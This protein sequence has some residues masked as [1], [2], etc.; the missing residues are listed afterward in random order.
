MAKQ[1]YGLS[2][3]TYTYNDQALAAGLLDSMAGWDCLPR[4]VLVVDDGSTV[5]FAA[6][7]AGTGVQVVRLDP[8]RGPA[9]AKIAGLSAAGSRFLL[10]LDADIRLD[11]DWVTRLLPVAARPEVGLV[12]TPIRTEA[13]SGLLADYQR[14]L[15]SHHLGRSGPVDVLPAGVW[16][17]RREVWAR[18]G[19]GEYRER[20]HEDVY[21]SEKLRRL[22][23][24]LW[25]ESGPEA[26]QIRR[27]GRR[28]MVRRGWTWQGREFAAVARAGDG[29]AVN[30]LLMAVRRRLEAHGA[31]DVRF[32]YYDYLYA[33]FALTDLLRE[34]GRP[35]EELAALTGLLVLELP[36][37]VREVFLAD[38]A[39]LGCRDSFFAGAGE[40][41]L[42]GEVHR[43]LASILPPSF[44]SAVTA[45]LPHLFEED[46]RR[47]WHFSFYDG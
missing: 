45:A 7:G 9:Q 14:L 29:N 43:A 12:A 18:F 30:A 17:L 35:G 5:P 44:P 8:N 6:P 4:D 13:G 34:A 42:P 2:V 41:G 1:H 20:L 10:S 23:L 28:T 15:Y 24:V 37:S 27:L 32:W 47:D 11:P 40:G 33:A 46:Q 25:L 16:L 19:F 26:R 39:A 21:F 38:M 31:V 36:E 22:G 3:I